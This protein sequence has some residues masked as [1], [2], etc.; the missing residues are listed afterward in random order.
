MVDEP[1]V[2]EEPPERLPTVG[3]TVLAGFLGAGKTTLLNQLVRADHGVRVGILV[4][5][6][7][8]IDIDSELVAN[9]DGETITLANGCICCTIRDDLLLTLFRLLHRD[10]AP[11]HV[12]IEC[13]GVSDPAAVLAG[14]EEANM[15]DVVNID[16]LVVVVDAEQFAELEYR[17]QPLALHQL[18]VSDLVVL[19]KADLVD[20]AGLKALEARIRGTVPS[21][22]ILRSEFGNVPFD[23]VLGVGRFD[24]QRL[25]DASPK[26]VHVHGAKRPAGHAHDDGV[27]F[28]SWSFT[29]ER[30]LDFER[31]RRVLDELPNGIYRAKGIVQLTGAKG[32]RVIVQVVGRRI[33]T[34][35]GSAWAE[36][37]PRVSKFVAIG[38]TDSF[39]ADALTQAFESCEL[40]A[41]ASAG[42]GNVVMRWIRKLWLPKS[43]S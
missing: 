12:I 42:G 19:N 22:R 20:E 36:G 28:D 6:F 4:N 30:A 17:D 5:D 26:E 27:A 7:G 40:E 33:A 38:A 21:A 29:T 3:L 18:V 31:L 14:F 32:R 37:E 24:P 25:L 34:E 1:I 2:R 13:S 8:E 23:L 35:Y 11:E 16:S 39:D 15:F 43:G 9:A 41:G 10:D